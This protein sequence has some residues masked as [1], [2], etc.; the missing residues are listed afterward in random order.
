MK[1]YKHSDLELNDTSKK[2]IVGSARVGY[3]GDFEIYVNTDDPGKLPHFHIRDKADWSNFHSCIRLD[4]AEYF[5]HAGKEDILNSRQRKELQK[6]MESKVTVPG[7]S[8]LFENNWQFACSM[9]NANN[10]DVIVSDDIE[11]PDYRTL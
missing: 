6:F 7:L 9:W 3:S 11:M 10:S 2:E 1:I 4:C 5:L 8:K